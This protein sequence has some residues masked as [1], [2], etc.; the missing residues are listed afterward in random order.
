MK[1]PPTSSLVTFHEGLYNTCHVIYGMLFAFLFGQRA[2][3]KLS[4]ASGGRYERGTNR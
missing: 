3:P 1:L 2:Q 4:R